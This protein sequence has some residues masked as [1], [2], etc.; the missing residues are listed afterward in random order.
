MRWL[1]WS[2]EGLVLP[3]V[4]VQPQK[5]QRQHSAGPTHLAVTFMSLGDSSEIL[6]LLVRHAR[7]VTNMHGSTSSC[8]SQ[9]KVGRS[10]GH[11][12]AC[13]PR[14]KKA[15]MQEPRAAREGE[16]PN[17]SS[18]TSLT[19]AI[20]EGNRRSKT[21]AAHFEKTGSWR[22]GARLSPAYKNCFGFFNQLGRKMRTGSFIKHS[23]TLQ[24]NEFDASL[25]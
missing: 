17:F 23:T 20:S 2:H 16:I 18:Q 21:A 24:S 13:R 12:S 7:E 15:K 19:T 14:G 9:H 25:L 6:S 1:H 4:W 8:A 5:H 22:P 10:L 3:Q 11:C